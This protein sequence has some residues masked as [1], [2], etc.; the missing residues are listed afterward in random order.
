MQDDTRQDPRCPRVSFSEEEVRSFYRPWSKALVVK[1]M[2][3]S[4]AFATVKRRLDS[5]WGRNGNIQA[6]DISNSFFLVRFADE[7]DYQRAAFGG[8][9]KIFDYYFSVARWSPNFNEEEPIKTIL[10]WVRLSK[11]PI[12][13]FNELAVSR[14]GNAIGRTVRLDLATSE[15][16]R[17]RYARVCV[18]VDLT[19][20][21]LGKYMIEDR[22]FH[23][24]YESLERICFNCGIYGH[25]IDDCS[26]RPSPESAPTH[27]EPNAIP[28]VVSAAEG[29]TGEWMTVQRRSKGHQTKSAPQPSRGKGSGSR[30]DALASVDPA[31][32]SKGTAP[33]VAGSP[34]HITQ[35]FADIARQ[36]D[37][38]L[39]AASAP[40][41]TA[42]NVAGRKSNKKAS[43]KPLSDITNVEEGVVSPQPTKVTDGKIPEAFDAP[44]LGTI[45][46]VYHNPIFSGAPTGKPKAKSTQ[47]NL[48]RVKELARVK[49]SPKLKE[50]KEGRQVRSFVTSTPKAKGNTSDSNGR[51]GKPPDRH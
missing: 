12:H 42:T 9:W 18:E 8:P 7:E 4:F 28:Q 27:D 50:V 11:L 31:S 39:K 13:F 46:M 51:A 21:L 25:Q 24:E 10:M 45:S 48:K 16:A 2:E 29:T 20:P 33:K 34:T 36:L 22:T 43:Q 5:I 3:K 40:S 41:A 32:V 38:V 19:K 35:D 30:F 26:S 37:A 14:I 47:S 23:V 49:P 15:G 1:V 6:A 17:A 44:T